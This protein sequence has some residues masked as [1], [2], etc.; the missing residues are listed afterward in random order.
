MEERMLRDRIAA[1]IEKTVRE[2]NPQAGEQEI[3]FL[4]KDHYD[5]L[6]QDQ[7]SQ[8]ELVINLK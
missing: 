2:E 3:R 7:V 8:L 6:Y 1:D 5:D 4:I